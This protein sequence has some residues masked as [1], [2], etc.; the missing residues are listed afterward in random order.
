MSS[1]R[2]CDS[3]DFCDEQ[4]EEL[5]AAQARIKVLEDALRPFKPIF[6][7]YD[8]DTRPDDT[9]VM[10]HHATTLAPIRAASAAMKSG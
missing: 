1:Y 10:V 9:I 7:F 3:R 6:D 4:S 2:E 8:L 5:K